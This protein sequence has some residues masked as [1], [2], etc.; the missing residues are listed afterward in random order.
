MMLHDVNDGIHKHR[1]KKRVGRGPGSG[2]GKTSTRGTKGQHS[3]SGYGKYSVWQGGTEPLIRRIPKRGFSNLRFAKT[4][5]A[6]NV[7]QLAQLV[8]QDLLPGGEV[9]PESL[10]AAGVAKHPYDYLKI[11]GDGEL[12][13]KLTVSAHKF[14][15]SAKEKIEK[16]GGQ[17]VV[18]PQ[19]AQVVKN[20]RKSE[21][22]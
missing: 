7:G 20:K 10:K 3:N 8:R 15:K 9:S 2:H 12:E 11:L 13:E 4:I 5:F 21:N 1:R 6:I 18:L 19:A 17:T 16:A 14:S 22:A